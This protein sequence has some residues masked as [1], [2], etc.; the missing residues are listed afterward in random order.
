VKA[1]IEFCCAW[2]TDQLLWT[3][4]GIL[5]KQRISEYLDIKFQR[6]ILNHVVS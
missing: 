4:Q 5:W 6:K 3:W 1:W 2:F